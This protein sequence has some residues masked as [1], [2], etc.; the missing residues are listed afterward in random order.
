MTL[1][2]RKAQQIVYEA[3]KNISYR[4]LD[5]IVPLDQNKVNYIIENRNE[6]GIVEFK[7]EFLEKLTMPNMMQKM[8]F[9]DDFFDG[10][11]GMKT[12]YKHE[13]TDEERNAVSKMSVIFKP[14]VENKRLA[15]IEQ[16][17]SK[18][19]RVDVLTNLLNR[20][21][22]EAQMEEKNEVG[23]GVGVVYADLDGLK[24]CN[25]KYGHD[26]GDK[27][28]CM[29]ANIFMSFFPYN[30][31]YRFGGDEFVIVEWDISQDEL[32]EKMVDFFSYLS[33]TDQISIS[34]GIV[35]KDKDCNVKEMLR[36]ADEKMY[37]TKKNYYTT[38]RH[39]DIELLMRHD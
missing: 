19:E 1:P 16:Y 14:I 18:L 6:D 22:F 17:I 4:Q 28:L 38:G 11:V 8:F 15:F 7:I 9:R 33:S 3:V 32:Y 29:A 34:V 31:I 24:E 39:G 13:W 27:M 25:D 5:Y 12:Y 30:S 2:D 20:N 23:K 21:A 37:E 26:E 36:I 10:A 35:W